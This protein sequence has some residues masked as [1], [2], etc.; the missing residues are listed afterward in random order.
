[1]RWIN[2]ETAPTRAISVWDNVFKVV[3][4]W[5]SLSKSKHSKCKSY[6][7]L[8]SAYKDKLTF[9]KNA[10]VILKCYLGVFQTDNPMV[11][12]LSDVFEGMI[13]KIQKI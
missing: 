7:V 5:E 11:P 1:M 10:A 4:Y 6:D 9:F 8:V 2:N 13:Q 3:T 12:F